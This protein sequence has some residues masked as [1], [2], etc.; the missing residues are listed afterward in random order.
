MMGAALE[1]FKSSEMVAAKHREHVEGD[2]AQHLFKGTPF[3]TGSDDAA[4]LSFIEG[5]AGAFVERFM[6]YERREASD[7]KQRMVEEAAYGVSGGGGDDSRTWVSSCARS[8]LAATHQGQ[9]TKENS[10]TGRDA[11]MA[12]RSANAAARKGSISSDSPW[13]P[14]LLLPPPPPPPPPLTP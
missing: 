8:A 6:A 2:T 14:P 9:S 10:T 7:W 12:S 13:E 5:P 3:A 4:K 1:W 11:T